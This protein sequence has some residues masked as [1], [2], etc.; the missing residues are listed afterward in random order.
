[1]TEKKYLAIG[2]IFMNG[3]EIDEGAVWPRV[4]VDELRRD[5]YAIADPVLHISRQEIVSQIAY[6]VR[7]ARLGDDFD[8]VT[9]QVGTIDISARNAS[10]LYA[11]G[12]ADVLAE[13]VRCAGGD[14]SRVVVVT[15][16]LFGDVNDE[17]YLE[18]FA[19]IIKQQFVAVM[20]QGEPHFVDLVEPSIELMFGDVPHR[21]EAGW[22]DE[23]IHRA[24]A[25]EVVQPARHV[26]GP[27]ERPRPTLLDPSTGGDEPQPA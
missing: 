18:N 19:E 3:P 9:I 14:G 20:E 5:G 6:L 7:D 27:V 26:L 1:M 16:P 11:M 17:E 4:L 25:L 13:G 15:P 12:F 10:P 23:Y 21:T 22:P 2:D 8:L 24:W